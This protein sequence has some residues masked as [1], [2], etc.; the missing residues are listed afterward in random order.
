MQRKNLRKPYNNKF[1]YTL[2]QS[3]NVIH[4]VQK[5]TPIYVFFYI[6]VDNV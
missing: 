6:S 5:K 2:F 4:C 1:A 3:F